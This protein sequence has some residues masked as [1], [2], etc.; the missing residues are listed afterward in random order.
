MTTAG[1]GWMRIAHLSAGTR[2]IGSIN[3]SVRFFEAAWVQ[4]TSSYTAHTNNA[5]FTLD[6]T[7]YGMLDATV[8]LPAATELR[9]SCNDTT[10]SPKADAYHTLA[11]GEAITWLDTLEYSSTSTSWSFSKNEASYT[12]AS[13]FARAANAGYWGNWHIC[14]QAK[15][16]T[17]GFQLGICATG[18]GTRDDDLTNLNHPP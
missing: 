17:D 2:T 9:F 13:V 1:G 5:G 15:S 7:T 16:G 8:I 3:R 6:G 12:P 11:A 4:G 14:G 18:P 10:R